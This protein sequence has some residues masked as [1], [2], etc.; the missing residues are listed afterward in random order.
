M[1]F[2]VIG[3]KGMLGTDLVREIESREYPVTA[4]DLDD[5][6]ITDP[7]AVAQIS[8]GKFD[9]PQWCIN[10]AAY[11]AVDKAETE[12]DAATLVNGIAPGYLAQACAIAGIRLIHISTDF[13]FDGE[14]TEPYTEDAATNPMGAYGRTKLFGETAVLN[15]SREAI[16]ARTAW[17]YGP[18]GN[19]FPKTMIKAW[20]AGKNLKVVADQVGTPTY[21]GDLAR[22]LVDLA[23]SGA[24]AGIYHATGPDVTTWHEF[25]KKAIE[26][27]SS[28]IL[29]KEASVEIEPL[30]T[31]DW[32]TPAKRPK[33]SALSFEK[34]AS[35]G[36]AP[37]RPM[38]HALREFVKLLPP[39][40]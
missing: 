30:K 12:A 36:I 19:S 38:D 40:Q 7:S 2:L 32:P 21:T 1:Q 26:I 5:L 39:L 35:V 3:A 29:G 11:T 31:E 4:I 28:E 18:N 34:I 16:V 8:A 22:V 37:M 14:A 6:D 25:A 17:L 13:V 23:E 10:C 33:Y 24:D 15:N 27:Y 9:I 20:L